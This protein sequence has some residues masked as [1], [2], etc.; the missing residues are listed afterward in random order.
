MR[1]GTSAVSSSWEPGVTPRVI[2]GC[3]C[4]SFLFVSLHRQSKDAVTRVCAPPPPA[5]AI[6][7]GAVPASSSCCPTRPA[8]LR[9]D[10]LA[11]PP[12]SAH[13]LFVPR[14]V[15]G[16]FMSAQP[17]GCFI[18]SVP[19]SWGCG[20]RLRPH[21]SQA[22][23]QLLPS[24]SFFHARGAPLG[25]SGGTPPSI[26]APSPPALRLLYLQH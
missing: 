22:P 18:G 1:G 13:Q 20:L 10:G 21:H 5:A 17:P 11:R 8:P 2:S 12:H 6:S 14:G 26:R 15:C 16:G 3:P 7:T 23:G 9:Q 4:V 19:C 24:A 25:S